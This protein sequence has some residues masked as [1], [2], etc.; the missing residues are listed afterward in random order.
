MVYVPAMVPENE[1]LAMV[2]LDN[3]C[4]KVMKA[5]VSL[6]PAKLGTVNVAAPT[7]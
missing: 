4:A 7:V 2:L 5:K 3:V 1:G 6:A